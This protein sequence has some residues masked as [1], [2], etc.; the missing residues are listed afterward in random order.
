MFLTKSMLVRAYDCPMRLRHILEGRPSRH[1]DDE[2]LRMLAEGGYQFEAIVRQALPGE[3]IGG[4]TAVA[5]ER[6]DEVLDRIAQALATGTELVLHEAPVC[7]GALFAR[8][9]IL[10]ARGGAIEMLEVKSRAFGGSTNGEAVAAPK[11]PNGDDGVLTAKSLSVRSGWRDYVA[12]IA[13]QQLVLERALAARGIVVGAGTPPVRA[14]LIAVN[15]AAYADESG[16]DTFGNVR[17]TRGGTD[18]RRIDTAFEVPPPPGARSQIPVMIDMSDAV[19]LLRTRHAQ[20][21]AARWSSLT[22]DALVD[23]AVS[24]ITERPPVDLE[25]ERSWKCRDCEFTAGDPGASGLEQCWG[26]EKLASVRALS[27]LYYGK[28]YRPAHIAKGTDWLQPTIEGERRPLRIADLEP[29]TGDGARADRRNMQIEA[30]RSGATQVSPTF[31][32]VARE[33][34]HHRDGD[35]VLRFLDFETAMAAL[36]YSAGARPYDV[37]PFQFSCHT[38]PVRGGEL[39]LSEAV[40]REWLLDP[41]QLLLSDPL[42]CQKLFVQALREA[43]SRR[44]EG[45]GPIFHWAAHEETVLKHLA[46]RLRAADSMSPEAFWLEQLLGPRDG[47]GLR[48][49][50]AFAEE[51]L[52]HPLQ[53]GRFSIK[54]VLPA[55]CAEAPALE[56]IRVLMK[57]T[58]LSVPQTPTGTRFDPYQGL[59]C[60]G[61]MLDGTEGGALIDEAGDTDASESSIATGT[62]AIRAF[63]QL[64]FGFGGFSG[65]INN[66]ALRRALRLYC[67]LDT[68]AMVAAWAWMN[69]LATRRR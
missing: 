59:P 17:V 30:E 21:G 15:S 36:P 37:T 11:S 51:H 19:A 12:D 46:K 48:D 50:R 20:S 24:I 10:R 57:G 69:D 49:M 13:F 47:Y 44:D 43:I 3:R 6:S 52:F 26:P 18:G 2:F 41:S 60:I 22:L 9:D 67:R 39:L 33:F 45:A 53:Q 7:H 16:W 31:D 5:R 40:H 35:G 64:R 38:I 32:A 8:V 42:S 63:H 61:A 29:D 62:D 1:D 28:G 23:D 58:G 54:T 25:L 55:I 66:G 14:F 65:A 56:A 34:L 68:A 27:T 4:G